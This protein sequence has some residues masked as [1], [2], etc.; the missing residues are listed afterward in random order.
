[1]EETDYSQFELLL[2]RGDLVLLYTDAL[3]EA[4]GPDGRLLGESGLLELVRGLD[5]YAPA[6]FPAALIS[7]LR[8]YTLDRPAG[9]D[10]T[11]LLLHH[12]AGPARHP[13]FVETWNVYAKAIGLKS[14]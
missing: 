10:L 2:G 13:G 3:T 14:V 4:E 1:L 9:D 12:N 6:S 5:P 8:S 11:F 7:A